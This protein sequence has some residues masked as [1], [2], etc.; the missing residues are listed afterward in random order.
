MESESGVIDETFASLFRNPRSESAKKTL[1]LGIFF[2]L[3]YLQKIQKI[4]FVYVINYLHSQYQ[5]EHIS[6][7]DHG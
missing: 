7:P 2:L 1:H 3:L 5:T 6:L 4:T